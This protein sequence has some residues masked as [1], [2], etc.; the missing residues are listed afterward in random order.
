MISRRLLVSSALLAFSPTRDAWS[1]QRSSLVDPFRLGVDFALYDSG[2]AKA[3]QQAFGRDTGVAVKLIRMPA[4]P[5]LEAI[6]RGEVDGALANAPEAEDKLDKQGLV[7]D[8]RAIAAGDF[9]LVGPAPRGK[10]KDPASI[11]GE[12]NITQALIEMVNGALAMPGAITFLS[13]GDGSGTYAL[14]QVLWRQAKLAP[15]PPWYA[16]A[17]KSGSVIAQAAARGAYTLVERAAWLAHG[18][19]GAALAVLVEGDP[20]LVESVHVMLSFRVNHP[21]GKLFVNWLAGPKGRR[22]AAAQR[23]YRAV[24]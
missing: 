4:L 3:L 10:V 20:L 15:R 18:G 13:A 1:Q 22:V 21:A 19:G 2:L 14:E 23:G 12:R 5:L 17:D 6:D 7:H 9:M 16:V 11:A 8:R 24:S